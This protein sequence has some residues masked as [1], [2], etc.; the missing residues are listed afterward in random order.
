MFSV[1]DIFLIKTNTH[2]RGYYNNENMAPSSYCIS[3]CYIYLLHKNN[4]PELNSSSMLIKLRIL[5]TKLKV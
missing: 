3:E 4:L 1:E 5:L 2:I